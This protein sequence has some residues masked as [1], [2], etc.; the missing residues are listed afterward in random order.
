MARHKI[1][2]GGGEEGDQ[3]KSAHVQQVIVNIIHLV[4]EGYQRSKA[5]DFMD[6]CNISGLSDC[7]N[8]DSED[9]RDWWDGT[10]INI[11]TDW[12]WYNDEQIRRWQYSVNKFF[13]DED[14]IASNWLYTFIYNLSTDSLRT[15]VTKK[16]KKLPLNQQG[17][18]M[19]LFLTLKE[20]FQMSRE[21]K[22]AIFKFLDIFKRNGVSRYTGENV[23]V[24]AEEI[25]GVCKRLDAVNSLQDD[26]ACLM[27]CRDW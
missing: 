19:Y 4:K 2:T 18:V 10:I 21:V 14:R 13:G 20:M 12:E 25:L 8:L 3:P 27:F 15:A 11:W 26:H 23:L 17:G 9:P 6:I 7:T 22:D 5:M 24:V 1:T 16:Y